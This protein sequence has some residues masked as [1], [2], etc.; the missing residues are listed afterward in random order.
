MGFRTPHFGTFQQPDQING[1]YK[2]LKKHNFR[3]SSSVLMWYAHRQQRFA[4]PTA[5]FWEFP[6]SARVGPPISLI[7]SWN[8]IIK[9][10]QRNR[11][12]RLKEAWDQALAVAMSSSRPTYLNVYFDPA[13]VVNYRPFES[14]LKKISELRNQDQ[15]WF[16][17][18]LQA[19]EGCLK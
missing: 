8:M 5:S 4:E 3:Y 13:H 12:A 19:W 10:H 2:L 11:T 14:M 9:D 7:D 1:L 15:V 16:G 18:Y 6:I 17:N